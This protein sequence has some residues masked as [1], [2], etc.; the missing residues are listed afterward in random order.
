MNTNILFLAVVLFLYGLDVKAQDVRF[1]VVAD[2]QYCDC[3]NAPTYNRY[4]AETKGRLS[5]AKDT[6]N[7]HN[8]DFVINLGDIID[9]EWR[10]FDSIL[11][12]FDSIQATK[13][14][15]LGNH[16][17]FVEDPKKHKVPQRLGMPGRYYHFVY[18]NWRFIVLDAN[19]M[20]LQAYPVA[21]AEYIQS[22]TLYQRLKSLEQEQAR[23]WN[24][25]IGK[26]QQQWLI[27]QLEAATM[28]HQHVIIFS[29]IPL[30]PLNMNTLWNYQDILPILERYNCVKAYFSGHYHAGNYVLKDRVHH[31]TFKAILDTPDYN[32]FSI[33]EVTE[34]TIKIH[35]YGREDSRTLEYK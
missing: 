24:G 26:E 10:S 9:R 32:A 5:Q 2:V 17:F 15:V 4:F 14:H 1:G 7:Q 25:A 19:D 21:S 28:E 33:V 29:H 27:H 11:P 31:L 3:D 8:L 16:D 22:D 12:V 23:E 34:N 20:S 18:Q 6:F 13:Y 35:G 30:V